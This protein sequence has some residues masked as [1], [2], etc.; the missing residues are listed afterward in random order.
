MATTS[1]SRVK[2]VFSSRVHLGALSLIVSGILFILYPVL[3][4]FS[5][6]STLQ[7]AEA[8]ASTAWVLSHVLAVVAFILLAL[9]LLGLHSTFQKTTVERLASLAL[10]LIWIGVG[11]TLPYYGAEIFALHAIGQ[12][13]VKQQSAALLPL[14]DAV[15]FSGPAVVMF[16]A[17]LLL[18]AVGPILVAIAVWR[19]GMLSRW[20]VLSFALGFA[21]YIP[22]FFGSQ[23]I[24]VAHGLMVA[25]GCIWVALSMVRDKNPRSKLLHRHATK[26]GEQAM[27][28][29][30]TIS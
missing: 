16:A 2:T 7:G 17:G 20:S 18:L 19:S 10:I 6:E 4:P 3:R 14:V 30:L 23:P 9:G 25:L 5:D 26:S 15:R 11:F 1:S 27:D 28:K 8:F 21:L 29:K 13:A 24:R 22:Q 12:E